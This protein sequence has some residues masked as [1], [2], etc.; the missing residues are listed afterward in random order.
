MSSSTYTNPEARCPACL[1]TLD[2]ATDP[3]GGAVPQPGDV[4]VCAYCTSVL[5]FNEDLTLCAMRADE[6]AALPPGLRWRLDLLRKAAQAVS[7]M[8]EAKR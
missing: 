7:Q 5:V 6:Y 4:S 8:R 1:K 3:R 2:G